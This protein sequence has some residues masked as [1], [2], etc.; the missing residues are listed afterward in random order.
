MLATLAHDLR[1][2]VRLFVRQPLLTAATVV[3]LTLGIG[4][5]AG[6]F[7]VI[8]GLLFR[9]RVG[10]DPATFVELDVQPA[11]VSLRDYE[12]YA[13][14]SSLRA[15]TAWTPAHA[16]PDLPLLVTC[17]FF[18]VYAS[19]QP[20]L[21]RVLRPDDC[22]APDAASVAV[23][24][25]ELWRTR[26]GAD[27]AVVGRTLTLNSHA[28]TIVGVMPREYDGELRGPIWVPYTTA[29]VFFD[30]RAI[31]RERETPWLLGMTGRLQPGVS[32]AAAAAELRVIAQQQ[33]ELVPDRRTVLRVTDGSMI[34]A[35]MV[36]DLAVW[37]IPIVMGAL[38]LVLLIACLNVAV[39]MLSRAVA[40]RHEMAVRTSLGASHGRLVQMLLSESVLLAAVAAPPSLYLAYAVPRAMKMLIPT[41]PFYPFAIDGVVIGYL[42]AATVCAGIAAG[43]APAVE[44]LR[45]D[46]APAL[47]RHGG[48]WQSV[49][50]WQ[51]RDLLIAGQVAMSLVLLVGAVLFIRAERALVAN[52]GFEID[53][54]IAA[55]PRLSTPPH[56]PATAEAFYRTLT[57][58][59]RAIPGV[60]TTAYSSAAGTDDTPAAPDVVATPEGDGVA[61]PA[62]VTTVTPAYFA[63]IDL[64]M[65]RGTTWPDETDRT[66]VV[67]S[68][69]LART[70]FPD[71]DPI[72]E[73]FRLATASGSSLR[74]VG[75]ARDVPSLLGKPAQ[76]TV[77]RLRAANAIGDTLL[78]RFDGDARQTATAIRDAIVRLDPNAVTE[79]RTMASIRAETAGKFMRL[80]E[81]IVF[82]AG[83]ALLLASIGIYGAVAFAVARRMKEIAIRIALGATRRHVSALVLWTGWKPIA[84][85]LAAGIAGTL[86]VAPAVARFFRG[87]PAQFDPFDP[88]AYGLVAALLV[89][90]GTLAMLGP[91]RRAASSEPAAALHQD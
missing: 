87:T 76:R 24:G 60:R 56:T 21:G 49:G 23:I 48:S 29:S 85:G 33:D 69:S 58:R 72:G 59:V 83:V 86:L 64:G 31:A 7:T 12:A 17:N 68:E 36:R 1:Y 75:V 39:L 11:P 6:V 80:V 46:V 13:R 28:F 25:E 43:L 62:A 71:R 81:M 30:G 5:N 53:H 84:G 35:P 61:T 32:R 20:I 51:P 79:P 42:S 74:I 63:T 45:P 82:L 15:L 19:A 9:P 41:L 65:V 38:T 78:V 34:A 57:E 77:Y 37:V 22:A 47:H 2:A 90:A 4:L 91:C 67:V 44:S 66:A 73:R 27:T 40:R 55:M 10:H 70:L 52:P 8:N 26:F 18:A 16:A 54:V 88:I 14:A 3:T 50:R 89:A